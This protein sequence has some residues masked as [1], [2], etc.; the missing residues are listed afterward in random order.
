[1]TT[2]TPDKIAWLVHA[3]TAL[4]CARLAA[5]ATNHVVAAKLA[6]PPKPVVTQQVA[7]GD[8]PVI[9]VAEPGEDE[10][11]VDPLNGKS[12]RPVEVAAAGP[13]GAPGEGALAAG[14]A[15]SVEAVDERP[16]W[17][18]I[19]C[20]EAM[21]LASGTDCDNEDK[22]TLIATLVAADP[23]F[24]YARVQTPDQKFANVD[25]V[26]NN[27]LGDFTV[28]QICRRK[29]YLKPKDGDKYKCVSLEKVERARP[30]EGAATPA[31]PGE[32]EPEAAGDGSVKRVGENQYETTRDFVDK[33]LMDLENVQ[34]QARVQ[35]NFENGQ[36]NGFRIYSIQPGSVFSQLGLRNGDVIKRINGQE[37][38][39]PERG[40]EMY[41]KLKSA[42]KLAIDVQRR[43]SPVTLD[44]SIR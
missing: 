30:A 42:G 12:F 34:R 29:V 39:S 18:R 36:P 31:E 1:M 28:E 16:V 44:V 7:E 19:S 38:N 20:G 13:G 10:P 23:R 37:I 11:V 33:T 6:A 5:S 4:M 32:E 40:L 2:I 21:D 41:A 27:K 24:S 9:R 14:A 15:G 22:Y 17:E 25:L 43:G 26:D 8:G 3:L 35:L